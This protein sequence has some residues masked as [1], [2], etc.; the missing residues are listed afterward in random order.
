MPQ[1]KC[2]RQT[3]HTCWEWI[4]P[5]H[6]DFVDLMLW[7]ILLDHPKEAAKI[8]KEAE[9]F[10]CNTELYTLYRKELD[11]VL[12]QYLSQ[13]EP[14]E[15]LKEVHD[16]TCGATNQNQNLVPDKKDWLLLA[17]DDGRCKAISKALSCLPRACK[18]HTPYFGT[19]PSD[20]Y[21]LA[22]WDVGYEYHWTYH[23]TNLQ[24]VGLYLL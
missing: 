2:W 14:Q 7:G 12:F 4:K 5:W 21:H 1:N 13:Q 19:S 11:G 20:Y 23:F 15:V 3:K 22:V 24:N 17:D 10:H 6:F 16:G 8:I 9:K 18:F